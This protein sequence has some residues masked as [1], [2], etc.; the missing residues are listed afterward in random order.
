MENEIIRNDVNEFLRM[1]EKKGMPMMQAL[2]YSF[3]SAY[4]LLTLEQRDEF[5]KVY[6]K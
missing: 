6:S 5:W 3:A 4:S 2:S 1:C